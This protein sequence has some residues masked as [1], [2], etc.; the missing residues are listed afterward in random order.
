MT[1]LSDLKLRLTKVLSNSETRNLTEDK[2]G[3]ALNDALVFDVANY[4]P[5]TT[6]V[7]NSFTQAVDGVIRIPSNYRKLYSLH[8]GTTPGSTWDG[9]DMIDQ[10]RF[11]NQINNTA[12]ITEDSGVQVLKIHPTEDQGVDQENK[13]A[14]TDLG[15]F[16]ASSVTSLYQ[17]FT[18]ETTTFR[19]TTLKLKIVGSPTGT[20]TA[21]LYAT[22]S[23]LPTGSA[24]ITDS[25]TIEDELTTSYQ[26]VYFH[27][28]YTTTEDTEYAIVLSSDAATSDSSNYVSWAYSTSSQISDGTRGVYDGSVY[29][30]ATGDMYFITYTEEFLFQYSKRLKRMAGSTSTTG[31]GTEF[32]EPI[33]MLGAARLLER[34]AGGT[35]QTKLAVAHAL[36]YGSEGTTANPSPDSAY[37][38][39]NIIWDE[40]RVRTQTPRRKMTNVFEGRMRR[41]RNHIDRSFLAW[42]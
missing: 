6:L 30:T 14:T 23:S 32:E 24:L 29:A 19:G 39:L 9:Y 12:T 35:D 27:L 11:L 37:G 33:V 3:E 17:T 10:T 4:R 41:D 13:T 15:L 25:I 2:R 42:M 34:Q 28:P 36:R 40:F 31:M 7:E 16:T 22:S 5:W 21:G 26:F 1:T 8:Y 20:L 18:T 38:K